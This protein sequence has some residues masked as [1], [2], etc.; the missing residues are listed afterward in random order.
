MEADTQVTARAAS[1]PATAV[2]LCVDLDGTLIRTDLLWE[3]MAR[4][5]KRNPFWLLVLP[6]WWMK[7]RACLKRQIAA[8]VA[9]DPAALPY[10]EPFLEF[11][12]SLKRDGRPLVLA[13]ASDGALARQVAEHVGLFDEVVASDG[14]TNLR[15][16]AKV[17]KL[18]EKFGKRGFDYAGNS[19]VDLA[20]WEQARAAIVVNASEELEARAGRLVQVSRTFCA[21]KAKFPEMLRAVRPHQWVKNL[22]IFVPLLTSHQLGNPPLMLGA[23]WAFVSFSLCASAVYLLNDLLDLDADRRHPSKRFRPFASG[24]LS[25]SVGFMMVPLLLVFGLGL[26]AWLSASFLGVVLLYLLLTTAYSCQL[27]QVALLDVF[28]LASLYTLRLIAGHEATGVRYSTWLLMFSMFIFLSL[29]LVKR[30]V[31]VASLRQQNQVTTHGRG[32]FV[33]DLELIAW[34]GAGSGYLAVLV[35]A[36]YVHSPEVRKLYQH[37][38]LLLLVCPL[39]LYWISRVWLIAHRGGM[40]G[41][42]VVFALKDR[43]SYLVGLLTLAVIWLATGR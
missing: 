28:I 19:A 43:A 31:E 24:D 2:P 12:R 10:H 38:A 36:L 18:T 27:K 8:R 23:L 41:D 14:Q 35:L 3:S 30:Y 42:P 25:L 32:Y 6:F 9:V 1:A 40:H 7:G 26:A 29:A 22:I 37:P 39:L 5:L 4:L 13:T 15:G 17:C 34:L 16:A 21:A 20:V 11:L 33:K